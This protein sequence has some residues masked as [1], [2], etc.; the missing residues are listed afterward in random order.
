MIRDNKHTIS[1]SVYN[2]IITTTYFN[3]ILKE[4]ENLHEVQFYFY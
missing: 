4:I 1:P 2:T 3:S